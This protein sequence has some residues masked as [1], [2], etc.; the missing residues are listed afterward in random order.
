MASYTNGMSTQ[1]SSDAPTR[2]VHTVTR[3]AL[4]QKAREVLDY[5]GP[6]MQLSNLCKFDKPES[7][8]RLVFLNYLREAA[9]FSELSNEA[10]RTLGGAVGATA[11]T[12]DAAVRFFAAKEAIPEHT[13]S[14]IER[15]FMI[16]RLIGHW[17]F[18]GE[19]GN[20][21][22]QPLMNIS[23]YLDVKN[24]KDIIRDLIQCAHHWRKNES[25][26][27]KF[28]MGQLPNYKGETIEKAM[29][30]L[31]REL[32][33]WM[34]SDPRVTEAD[35]VTLTQRVDTYN[36]ALSQVEELLNMAEAYASKYPKEATQSRG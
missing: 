28:I 19:L 4:M 29:H 17:G 2:T 36:A 35:K 15:Y 1:R 20:G 11:A 16:N 33:E 27:A 18:N 22:G 25:Q 21:F 26:I 12:D 32:T 13:R 34:H 6:F 23:S 10:K 7:I 14:E 3:E 24:D 5:D 30:R 9:A 31:P 8:T